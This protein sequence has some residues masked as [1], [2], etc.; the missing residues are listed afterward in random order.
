MTEILSPLLF[1]TLL[2]WGWARSV[3]EHF[4]EDIFVNQT[5]PISLL[6]KQDLLSNS[7][8]LLELCPPSLL[9]QQRLSPEELGLL[10]ALMREEVAHGFGK[11]TLRNLTKSFAH[12]EANSYNV[13]SI[14]PA[15][16]DLS[17]KCLESAV[18][19]S[20]VMKT[21]NAYN[22]PLPV[23]SFD[24]FVQAHKL[25]QRSL[26]SG[27]GQQYE[28]ALR[29]QRMFGNL[30]GN[31]LQ[32]GYITFAPD[33]PE[34][35]ALVEY[36]SNST[37][38]FKDIYGG[39]FHSEQEAEKF[40]M[41]S[42]EPE[43][44]TW[45]IIVVNDF[46][47]EGGN[48]DYK[49]RMNF[50][51]VPST[52][53]TLHK[54]RKGLL[55]YYKH[56]YT[57]GFLSLQ[58]AING[59]VLQRVAKQNLSE[60]LTH[61][62]VW[63]AP[64]PTAA[65]TRNRFYHKV[66]PLLEIMLC[67]TALYPLG[68][69]VKGMVEDKESRAK[70]T[71]QIMGLKSWVFAVSWLMT[72]LVIFLLISIM[73]T[74]LLSMTFFP[75]SDPSLL[76]IL[77]FLFTTSL[78]SFG[79][80][81]SVLF[82]RSKL[83]AIVAPFILFIA[84]MPRYL[85][86][87]TSNGEAIMGKTI[88][89]LLPPTAYAFGVDLL[90]H[91]EKAGYG[92]TWE[93]IGDDGYSMARV[94]ILLVA[95]SVLYILLAWYLEQV[96]PSEFGAPQRPWFLFS[97]SYW[98]N[99]K[100]NQE[101]ATYQK[102]NTTDTMDD[103]VQGEIEPLYTDD[104][105]A[106]I[107]I[108]GLRKVYSDGKVAVSG[109]TL[110]FLEDHIT[111][112]LGHNG[113]GKSTTISMLTGLIQPSS[114]DAKIWGR[115][116][117][118]SMN[119]VRRTIGLC[120][121]QNVLFSYLTVKEHLELYAAVKG[122]PKHSL[123]LAVDDMVMSL[124]L[125]DKIETRAENLSGG[126]QRKLQVGMAM[127]GGSRVVFLD[128]P[129]CGLDPQSRR[130][131]WELLRN[132]KCGRAIVLTTHY[133]DEADILCDR[134]AIMSDGQLQCCGSSLFLKSRYGVGYNLSMTRSNPSCN[135]SAV[136]ELVKRHVPQ[137]IPL[138]SAGGE[139][140]FQLQSTN[141]AAFA[142]LF[143]ELE[144]N[145]D[146]LHIGSYG[147]SMTTLEEVFLRL[148]D[149]D[150]TTLED[151]LSKE[152]PS[153]ILKSDKY[154]NSHTVK[155]PFRKPTYL[156]EKRDRSFGRAFKQMFLKRAI[157]A[158]R[159][160][161]A[162]ANSILLPVVAI[163]LVMLVM[164]LNIDPAGPQ[165][166]LNFDMYS[167]VV[168]GRKVFSP[169]AIIPVAGPATSFLTLHDASKYVR[170][171]QQR[172]VNNSVQMS[173]QLLQT[174]YHVPARFGAL[175]F[176]DTLWPRL[177]TS[178]LRELNLTQVKGEARTIT[179][180]NFSSQHTDETIGTALGHFETEDGKGLF[181]SVTLLFNTTSDHSFP[182]LIQELAQVAFQ[183]T[184]KNT[185][186]TL[187]MSSHPLPLTKNEALRVQN[188]LTGLA[189]LFTLIPLSYCA[190]SF[191]VFVVQERVVKAKLLQMVSGASSFSYW[192]AAYAWD[193]LSYLAIVSTTML[194]LVLY[195]DQSF[196]GSWAKASAAVALL[197]AFG[198]AVVPLTYCYSFAF[199]NH[200]NAQVAIAGL[201]L[202][203]GFGMLGSSILMSSLEN[204]KVLNEHLILVYQ[205]FP[206]YNLG[207]GLAN[208]ASLD[209]ESTL[210][211]RASNPY[212]W[213]VTG[214]SLALM[215]LEAAV[216]IILTLLIDSGTLLPCWLSLK[217]DP[218]PTSFPHR[219]VPSGEE[220]YDVGLERKR[221]EGGLASE[222]SVVVHRLRKV[223]P[224]QGLD[225]A[226][227]AVKNLS[228]GIPPGQC[229]GFLGVNGAGKTTTLSILSGDIKP[230]SGDAFITGNSVLTELAAAQKQIGY[231]PQF[232]PLLDFMT[233]REHL[234]LYASLKGVP[235]H[236][237]AEV[238]TDLVE[239]VGLENYVDKVAGSYSG[240]NKRKLA[241]S[242]ALIG[243]P[244]VLFLD[245]PSSGMDPV[246]RR[247][248]WN[249]IANAVTEKNMSAVL[250][251]HSMEECEALCGRVGVMVAG[252]LV[253]LGSIQHIKSRFGQGYTVELQCATSASLVKLHHFMT[254]KFP[255]AHLEEEHMVRVKYSLSRAG[256]SLSHVFASLETAKHELELEDYSVSQ[257][258]LEQ[259]FLSLANGHNV[260]DYAD[261]DAQLLLDKGNN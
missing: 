40:A 247:A 244:A 157:I 35:T 58:D 175:V 123:P 143:Q 1:M 62:P 206:P 257:S 165:L 10:V 182:A 47:I 198:L 36:L 92:L 5:L 132:F 109:L 133:M 101:S 190:A 184:S 155:M 69:L 215:L 63:G 156:S 163:G 95:D 84:L 30:L 150:Q 54:Q 171:D 252:S 146:V 158:R 65:R 202:I 237:I 260:V 214:R 221:V 124:G 29:A 59:Y 46:D 242:I 145:L 162:F 80:F 19:V 126:M 34:V 139:M 185:S 42:V 121:Q 222:D 166:Q 18:Q 197:I 27:N 16:A 261:D 20:T 207:R 73:M 225:G 119:E 201:H 7:K 98:R 117:L 154:K 112:L 224:D 89:S 82:S 60:L 33:S 21:F 240:G 199:S 228:L 57:S 196:T 216:F 208:L 193:M 8:S 9:V 179:K 107:Q 86:F 259:V 81:L 186:A 161:K 100:A 239:A 144:K 130:S 211:G 128:E 147:V 241:L 204:T 26:K 137:A 75:R 227:V 226:K 56:Y 116:I 249:L 167:S 83:A 213:D 113:A 74:T 28:D 118:S 178:S 50:T 111:A 170:F 180:A 251:T 12:G 99:C 194:V 160:L 250:T 134:I 191:A 41:T 67:L 258:T 220:D 53:D 243:D 45:A 245:E 233:A 189:A 183:T 44:P 127:I 138:S 104:Q 55:T 105:E 77:Y 93:N 97:P 177:N 136:T 188:I 181:S 4:Q 13:T 210:K 129:T 78:I 38:F 148:A 231:C 79:F 176:N 140:S 122:V 76:F 94:L 235:S 37:E 217:A 23:P 142:Q 169:V 31:L 236:N 24:G 114:G 51:T 230:T 91:Y 246:T 22:G 14:S 219:G 120:P 108:Q 151:Q 159:D 6:V 48:V 232:N 209:L 141:K 212:L 39:I 234:H 43:R 149:K 192:A 68:M 152:N 103:I 96:F 66:G 187:R 174:L 203:T 106:S 256:L 153:D 131:V 71:M 125:K 164:K 17:L 255:G 15:L 32:L 88:A 85:F 102:L 168:T 110:N 229:F 253:C 49:I 72:Y 172:G 218:V 2:V 200:A 90:A 223:Y 61:E 64:F 70:Q 11:S 135:D 173:Q 205:L 254:S 248:M 25:L 87:R 52:W 115:S 238:V 3:E 195:Q